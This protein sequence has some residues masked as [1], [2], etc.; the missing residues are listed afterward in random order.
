[1]AKLRGCSLSPFSQ[2]QVSLSI[3]SLLG[4]YGR[5]E[6]YNCP[7]ILRFVSDTHLPDLPSSLLCCCAVS[8]LLPSANAFLTNPDPRYPSLTI[9]LVA[10]VDWRVKN[11]PLSTA[12]IVGGLFII[13]AF[14][15]LSW[16][17]YREMNEERRKQW[18]PYL[19][20]TFLPFAS[21][22]AIL[23]R[24]KLKSD[25]ILSPDLDIAESDTEEA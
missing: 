18:A 14:I 8:L 2:M 12:A 22:L 25:R 7:S 21:V 10:V 13:A 16:S 19:F 4:I 6:T 9:F 23:H 1:M 17:T 24:S 11:E 20:L 15:M 5:L 3:I